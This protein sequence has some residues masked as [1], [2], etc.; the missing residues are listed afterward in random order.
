MTAT[1]RE[2]LESLARLRSLPHGLV[3]PA[4]ISLLSADGMTN[5]GIAASAA[6]SGAM[7]GLWRKRFLSHGVVGLYDGPRPGGPRSIGDEKIAAVIRKTLRTK[8]KG[9]PGRTRTSN[10]RLRRPFMGIDSIGFTNRKITTL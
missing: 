3:R 4:R 6:L 8:P 1:Q 7:V 9:A 2:E 10:P 5:K